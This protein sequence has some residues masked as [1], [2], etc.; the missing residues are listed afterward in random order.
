VKLGDAMAF[1]LR[2]KG[3][4]II[5]NFWKEDLAS[6]V[7]GVVGDAV[8]TY[9][10]GKSSWKNFSPKELPMKMASAAKEI[11]EVTRVMPGRIRTGL[12]EFQT[13]MSAELD[14]REDASKKALFCLQVVGIL[15]TSTFSTYYN[16]KSTSRFPLKSA[17]AQFVLAELALRSMRLFLLR[18]LVEVESNVTD[19]QDLKHLNYFVRLLRDED[20]GDEPPLARPEDAAF[21]ITERLKKNILNGDDEA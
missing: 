6:I 18:F 3:Q 12:T 19:E 10:Q 1:V 7:T 21:N 4:T 20:P 14:K 17:V 16:L 2:N 9:Q 15:S 8:K 11:F 13:D 5:H